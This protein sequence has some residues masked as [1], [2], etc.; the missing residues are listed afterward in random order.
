MAL[1]DWYLPWSGIERRKLGSADSGF[2][3][4]IRHINDFD[5]VHQS[6]G[7]ALAPLGVWLVKRP[8]GGE[9]KGPP[10]I[11][12]TTGPISK[13]QTPFDSPVH[14]YVNY[15]KKV[16]NLT[17]RSLMTSQV[18]SKS[19]C[20]NFRDIW[21]WRAKY[22]WTLA[23]TGVL[24]Y[25]CT[26]LGFSENNS[27][28]DWPIVTEFGIPNLWTILHLIWKC[29]ALTYYDIWPVTWFPR[30]YQAKYVFRT[31]STPETCDLRYFYWR[32]GHGKVLRDDT[33]GLHWHCDRSEVISGQWPLM[34]S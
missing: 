28:T 9:G 17:W 23:G 31:V 25:W 10:E 27:R 18:M 5:P 13:F 12:Q 33:H 29:K 26:L 20:S 16:K 3:I 21:A 24:T 2:K 14:T 7:L 15:P 19:K 34:T 6:P 22:R 30:S 11:S 32:Y 8:A 1:Y 4:P